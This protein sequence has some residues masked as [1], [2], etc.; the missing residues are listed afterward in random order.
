[1]GIFNDNE[2]SSQSIIDCLST[3]LLDT[4]DA[5]KENHIENNF[6][7][8]IRSDS[9]A[10][11]AHHTTTGVERTTLILSSLLA[12]SFRF[13]LKFLLVKSARRVKNSPERCQMIAFYEF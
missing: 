7:N 13:I 3:A 6:L 8:S 11:P 9:L 12:R 1:M 2:S 5:E 10:L 4:T